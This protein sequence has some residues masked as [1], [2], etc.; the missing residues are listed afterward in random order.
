[1]LAEIAHDEIFPRDAVQ[2]KK[3]II[4]GALDLQMLFQGK[5][6]STSP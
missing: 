3:S 2:V 5:E 1:M 4:K 6:K